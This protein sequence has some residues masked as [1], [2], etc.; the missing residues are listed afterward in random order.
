[1]S[2]HG[3]QLVNIPG[4]LT[5]SISRKIAA[6]IVLAVTA[7]VT[8]SAITSAWT[9]ASS[10]FERARSDFAGIAATLA[11]TVSGA[12]AEG[13]RAEVQTALR[14]IAALDRIRYVRVLDTNGQRLAAYGVGVLIERVGTQPNTQATDARASSIDLSTLPVVTPIIHGG[15]EVGTF[16]LIVDLSEVRTAARDS[17]I[18]AI[19]IGL[20]AACLGVLATLRMQ[21]AITAPITALTTTM[22]NVQAT[23]DYKLRMKRE[24]RDEIGELVDAFN[25]MLGEVSD[26]DRAL[27]D[28]RDHLED[29]VHERTAELAEAKANADAA[30]AAKSEFLAMMSHEIRT[31]LNGLLVMAEMLSRAQLDHV[32]A[33][34]CNVIVAS[35]KTLLAIINDILDLSKIEAG[36]VTLESIPLNPVE[37]IDSV[38]SLFADRAAEKGLQLTANV[39][40]DIPPTLAGDPVRLN[41]IISNLVNNVIKFTETDGVHIETCLAAKTDDVATV[42]FTV[43]DSGIGIAADK[44]DQLFD[45][46]T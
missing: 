18:S 38:V 15:A 33:Q 34:R 22:R 21:Q 13:N 37:A 20:I 40:S 46:F 44:I 19:L 14:G 25:T 3:I 24:S 32:N 8:V 36:H 41:Q 31:P 43:R 5:R 29:K 35:G 10:R 1:M 7:A 27:R 2:G 26:R 42:R 17:I 12:V 11:A 4:F 16:E 6:T 23:G 28:H 9:D 45:A 39:S 30:N